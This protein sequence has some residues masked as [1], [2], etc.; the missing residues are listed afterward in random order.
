[1]AACRTAPVTVVGDW[2]FADWQPLYAAHGIA[3]FPVRVGAEGKMP[4]IKGWRRIGL[5]GSA[6]LAQQFADAN[7]LGFCL[8]RHGGLTILDVDTND[9]RT[10]ADALDHHGRTPIIVRSG[11]GNHQAWYRWHGEKRQIRP[12][13]DKPVDILGSGF[14]VAPPSYG[15]KSNYRFIEGSLEDLD[16]LPFLRGRWTVPASLVPA[17]IPDDAI[18]EGRR[19]DML[20]RHC[21]QSARHCD[22]FESLLDVARTRNEE[23]SPPLTDSEVVKTANS[24]WDYTLRGDNRFGRHGA[25]F[26]A[27][28]AN[29]LITSDQ[30]AF[31]LLA[32]L[33]A[34]NGPASTFMVAN[35][36]A[37]RL[38]WDGSGLPPHFETPPS[39]AS[40]DALGFAV[41]CAVHRRAWPA[42]VA[43]Y[44]GQGPDLRLNTFGSPPDKANG[45]DFALYAEY[46]APGGF[47]PSG[48]RS[49][50][51]N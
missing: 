26:D 46:V 16:H 30:D 49:A 24:A 48:T 40:P 37:E 6:A 3:T 2:S 9:E 27:E 11:S 22:D 39:F 29:R 35:G 38:G 32:F 19:N 4:A 5:P 50:G 8:G 41:A 23:F 18:T 7:A 44:S 45:I 17:P 14:V 47:V 34:N 13:P 21:M 20:W 42:R 36:L 1:M 28:E 12:D 31:V 43:Y 15:T 10:L 33:R 25:F 51:A